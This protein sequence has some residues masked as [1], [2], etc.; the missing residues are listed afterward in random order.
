MQERNIEALVTEALERSMLVV[1]SFMDQYKAFFYSIHSLL[2]C[3]FGPKMVQ[4]D[5]SLNIH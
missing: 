3:C 2:L 4:R 5:E 1:V